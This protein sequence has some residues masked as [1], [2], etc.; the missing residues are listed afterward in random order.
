[1]HN[2]PYGQMRSQNP[3]KR[4]KSIYEPKGRA[5]EY[6][7]WAFNYF[8]GCG[9]GCRYCYVPGGVLKGVTLEQFVARGAT[10]REDR[11]RKV[12]ADAMMLTGCADPVLLSFTSD[13]YQPGEAQTAITREILLLLR[14]NG[15]SYKILTKGGLRPI[16][17]FD[18]MADSRCQ[19]G[20]SLTLSSEKAR[21]YV[22]PGAASIADRVEGLRQAKARGFGRGCLPSRFSCRTR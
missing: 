7:P 12:V 10:V 13:P 2:N 19:F 9:H 14:D 17:D 18:I 21:R 15:V 6:A 8:F 11:I 3:P 5:R 4:L 1:M 16:R 20:V 22:E